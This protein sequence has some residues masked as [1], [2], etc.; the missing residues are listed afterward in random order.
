MAKV[1]LPSF[2]LPIK[3]IIVTQPWCLEAVCRLQQP[4]HWHCILWQ[5]CD[6]M[7]N[8]SETTL[9]GC[10][11]GSSGI[12]F[13]TAGQRIDPSSESTFVWRVTSTNSSSDTVSV[14]NYSNWNSTQPNYANGNDACM[15]I[16][17]GHSYT[18]NDYPCSYAM[19]SVCEMEI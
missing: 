18:W 19:C 9:S 12:F 14:M 7:C 13:W 4:H 16:L 17:S 15:D 3:F 10:D 11:R 5:S 1:T 2:S 8:I 6:R